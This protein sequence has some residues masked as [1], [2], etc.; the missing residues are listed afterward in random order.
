MKKS[1]A[2]KVISLLIA[3]SMLFSLTACG[4]KDT[5][6]E[7]TST[8]TSSVPG[9][10]TSDTEEIVDPLG[11]YDPVIE[12][13][14]WRSQDASMEFFDG[15]TI[16]NNI[17][18]RGWEN[19]LG[20]K[21]KY[22]WVV[23]DTQFEQKLNVAI[24]SGDLPDLMVVP[25]KQLKDL[26]E[27]DQL[28]DLTEVYE[29]Y[30]SPMVKD[31]SNQDPVS[32]NTAKI[33]GRLMAIPCMDS[34]HGQ[35]PIL[36]YRADWAKKLG[37]NEPKTMQDIIA[38]AEAFT[39]N[40]PDGNNKNDTYGIAMSKNFLIPTEAVGGLK[41]FFNGFH[42]YPKAWIKDSSG[43]LAYGSIQPEVKDA[44]LQLQKLYKDGII[45]KEFGVKDTAKVVEDVVSDKVGILFGFMFNP[46]YPLLDNI[47]QNL[48]AEWIPVPIP[49]VDD[50]L[51][52]P[53]TSVPVVNYCAVNKDC[54]YP[55]ALIKLTNFYVDK[56]DPN[57]P[58][59]D[60]NYVTV[61]G[62][63]IILNYSFIN[64]NAPNKNLQMHLNIKEALKT[65]DE[66]VLITPEE[67]TNYGRIL[68]Y[69]QGERPQWP[70]AAIFGL[71]TS[72]FEIIHKYI[73]NNNL[74]YDAF[75]GAPTDTMSEKMAT[76]NQREEE[77]FTRIV[78][79][80]P[81]DEFDKFVSD[82]K[83]LG[84]DQITKEVNERFAE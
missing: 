43:N 44:L 83:K 66:S 42:A 61:E 33:G 80:D 11:K 54:K 40:D 6:E 19:E 75:Y 72:A 84:G 39:K 3:L 23:P 55:E 21:I 13:T 76:L 29:K 53:M 22:V 59:Y 74:I 28:H 63:S 1:L 20:I 46:L 64:F 70:A 50:R 27:N 34:S 52:V 24:S 7:T 73:Q 60:I 37:L 25:S 2:M 5:K 51:A 78:L 16:D 26:A 38:M 47:N 82:W 48:D 15:D 9:E 36:W 32:F 68:R 4:S 62:E 14:A 57:S 31:I 10:N 71:E 65:G 35:I 81:I 18:T 69:Q 41:G 12:L 8:S 17:W 30:A 45:D 67:K 58:N 79:G 49:S 56:I 77:V